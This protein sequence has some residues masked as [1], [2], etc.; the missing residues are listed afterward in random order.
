MQ[1]RALEIET[2]GVA[3]VVPSDDL[4]D[5]AA[6][7]I[8]VDEVARAAQQERVLDRLL[9]MAVRAFDRPI[10]VRH[11]AIVAGRLHAVMRAQRLI[12]ARLI[13]PCVVLEIAEGGGQAVAAMLQ[14]RLPERP[15]RVQQPLG[16][17]HTA[18]AAEH[19]MTVFPAREGQ[20]E[21]VKPMIERR[22]GNADA[23]IAHR[24]EIG[25]P[26]PAGRMLL[27][28]DDITIGPIERPPA[29]DAPLQRAPDA[30]AD[31]GMAPADF[32]ENGDRPQTRQAF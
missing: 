24:G 18:L 2:L 22:T 1:G 8:Q 16:K 20:P 7:G 25:Q 17:R 19:E 21:M 27:P 4:I 11:A 13:L 14:G 3:R 6:I 29:P 28:E 31:L 26:Q 5:E 15:H 9:E 32:L 30:G 10:L 12:A 23:E